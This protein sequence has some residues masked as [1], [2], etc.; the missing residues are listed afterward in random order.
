MKTFAWSAAVFLIVSLAVASRAAGAVDSTG[1][2]LLQDRENE[3]ALAFFETAVRKNSGDAEAQYYL[4][5]SLQRLHRMDDAQ[6]A[7]EAALEKNDNVSKYHYLRGVILGEKARDAN[8]F[9]QG[10]LAPK[11]KREFLRAAELDPKNADAH[12]GLFNFYYMAP[13][14]MG[15]SEEKAFEEAKIVTTL[16]PYKG[17]MML[18]GY[19]AKKNDAANTESEYKKA[20]EANP[21]IIYTYYQYGMFLAKQ[22]KT[23]QANAVFKKMIDADPKNFDAHYMYG[24]ALYNLDRWDEA[25]GKF[26]YALF[27][28]KNNPPS[29]WMLANSYEKKGMTQ[30]AKETY[31][32]LLQAEPSGKRADLAREKLKE[33]H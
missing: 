32:W 33:L 25:I 14:I 21:K 30:K 1:I 20:L 6:E 2:K 29:V 17:H 31:Q 12:A 19:Y 13:G 3:K 5:V 11:I 23:D 16:D 28:E 18:A 24:R 9:S 10:L 27:L 26:Q 8:V 15:G 4:A 22:K 7:I